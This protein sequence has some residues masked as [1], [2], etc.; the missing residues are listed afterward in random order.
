M[1][2]FNQFTNHRVQTSLNDR[3]NFIFVTHWLNLLSTTAARQLASRKRHMKNK[4]WV[5]QFFALLIGLSALAQNQMF[6]RVVS[7]QPTQIISIDSGGL[8]IWS[9]AVPGASCQI[10]YRSSVDTPWTNNLPISPI[11]TNGAIAQTR[12]PL[13]R[14]LQRWIV[15]F[16]TNGVTLD[17][18]G[19]LFD[20]YN[21]VWQPLA[22]DS[23]HA[24][25]VYV[26][27]GQSTVLL[28]Q[29]PLVR[30]VEPD[31]MVTLY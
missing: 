2:G 27:F 29:S 22:W 15:G 3:L 18:A 14:T 26:P 23:I 24:T 1:I 12:V 11:Q 16:Q 25:V 28:S 7:D 6:F 21:L 19:Q 9:N 8:L 10:Q 20:S 31:Y 30:Y 5:V 13:A 17:Q 4:F